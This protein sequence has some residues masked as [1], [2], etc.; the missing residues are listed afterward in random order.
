MSSTLCTQA[1]HV[2]EE[3]DIVRKPEGYCKDSQEISSGVG[4]LAVDFEQ[5]LIFIVIILWKQPVTLLLLGINL[6]S[7]TKTSLYA[8]NR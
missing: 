8:A 1:N 7:V 5:I 4:K 6:H 3:K 2:V